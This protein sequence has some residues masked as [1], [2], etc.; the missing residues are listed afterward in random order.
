MRKNGHK[1]ILPVKFLT[2]KLKSTWATFYSN[3]KF[4]SV[5]SAKIYTRFERKTS[6]MQNFQNLEAGGLGGD[7]FLTK[8]PK[9]TSLVDFA[10]FEPLLVQIRPRLFPPGVTTKKRIIQKITERLYLTY[11]RGIPHSTKFN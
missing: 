4:I 2:P 11:L 3:T 8:H 9:G 5:A 1:T 7:H 10:R 6:V